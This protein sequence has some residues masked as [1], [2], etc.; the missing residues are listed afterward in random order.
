MPKNQL[1]PLFAQIVKTSAL[2]PA[3][4]FSALGHCNFLPG[5]AFY[6]GASSGH[7]YRLS[8]F[9]HLTAVLLPIFPTFYRIYFVVLHQSYDK[10]PL[11]NIPFFPY[12]AVLMLFNSI[13]H[14]AIQ[15]LFI[16]SKQK[17]FSTLPLLP[18]RLHLNRVL[19]QA[20][21]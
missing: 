20:V 11:S 21:F 19:Y 16:L 13:H 6:M 7:F 15:Q 2:C 5:I 10:D 8:P 3:S 4:L 18:N 1:Q 14:S 17:S 12:F 9:L